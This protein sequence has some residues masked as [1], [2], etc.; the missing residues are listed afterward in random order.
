MVIEIVTGLTENQEIVS[1]PSS[2]LRELKD[3]ALVKTE[4][5]KETKK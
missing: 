2:A 3:G 1:G 4:K 5:K